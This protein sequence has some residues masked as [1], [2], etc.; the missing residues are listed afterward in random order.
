MKRTLP[1]L[2]AAACLLSGCGLMQ[3]LR[4]REEISEEIS[5]PRLD[6]PQPN[7]PP[8]RSPQ[9]PSDFPT[10]EDVNDD[11]I[12][13]RLQS[14]P[15]N[16]PYIESYYI[17]A[18]GE[19]YTLAFIEDG[20]TLAQCLERYAV[21]ETPELLAGDS[22][23]DAFRIGRETFVV[24]KYFR[25]SGNGYAYYD[26]GLDEE[27]VLA[28]F[29][30]LAHDK[31]ILY[32]RYRDDPEIKCIAYDF[33]AV[34]DHGDGTAAFGGYCYL[35]DR[36]DHLVSTVP[37]WHQMRYVPIP[38]QEISGNTLTDQ[39]IADMEAVNSQIK[40]LLDSTEWQE[41]MQEVP[42]ESLTNQDIE[43]MAAVDAKVGALLDS[44]E[45]RQSDTQARRELVILLLES[46]SQEGL[47][48]Y[49]A[50]SEDEDVISFSY[51]CGVWGGIKLTDFD[52]RMN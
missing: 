7:V 45:W 21:N 2:L 50:P 1:I 20:E 23:T 36:E 51:A 34:E 12:L 43:D 49:T 4:V 9:M 29:D 11:E 18:A 13:S 24:P 16:A 46:L 38:A 44:T 47:I 17:P 37:E 32:R 10:F 41:P 35:I 33:Y 40:E 28:N 25:M 27:S 30:L 3:E 8:T 6:Y 42:E 19:D 5:E 14:D 52:E 22:L 26:G 31:R 15:H 39:E 48:E